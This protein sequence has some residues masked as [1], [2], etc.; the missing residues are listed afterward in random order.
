MLTS[1]LRYARALCFYSSEIHTALRYTLEWI[2]QFVLF[3]NEEHFL[4]RQCASALIALIGARNSMNFFFDRL[5]LC[6][7]KWFS[8]ASKCTNLE[9]NPFTSGSR[10]I[11]Y[12]FL[13]RSIF[14]CRRSHCWPLVCKPFRFPSALAIS[15]EPIWSIFCT[16]IRTR[17]FVM[18]WR[19]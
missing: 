18:V 13:L 14:S 12:I 19:E 16:R 17:R 6:L 5:P 10:S 3:E 4:F 1:L 11:A 8:I 7:S 2:Y 15:F 9:V